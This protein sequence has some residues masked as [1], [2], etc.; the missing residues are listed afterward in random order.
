ME[1]DPCCKW[2]S[3]MAERWRALAEG[4]GSGFKAA[5]LAGY[6]VRRRVVRGADGMVSVLWGS[7]GLRMSHAE[8]VDFAGVLAEAVQNPGRYGGRGRGGR[9]RVVRCSVG[10]VTLQ[11]GG[12][13]VWV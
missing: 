2:F 10:Q 4:S 11:D 1:Y 6:S 13:T 8:F 12:L 3:F 5:V 7:L 9:A